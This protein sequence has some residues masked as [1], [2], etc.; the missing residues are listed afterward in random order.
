MAPPSRPKIYHLL[1]VDKLSSVIAEGCIWSD[2]QVRTR[3]LGGTAVGLTDIKDRRLHAN[4]LNSHPDLYI[5]QCVPFYFCA[6]SVMLYILF[7]GNH[8]ELTYKGGQDP[9]LLPGG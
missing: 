4:R 8:P 6:R 5:G 7:R 9:I 1:H 2:A 3:R